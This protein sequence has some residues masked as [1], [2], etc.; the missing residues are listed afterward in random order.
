MSRWKKTRD[1]LLL[2]ASDANL[3]F[4]EVCSL[5]DRLGFQ[6][7]PGGGGHLIFHHPDLPEIINLQPRH[8]K[9]KPYQMK[10]VR[11]LILRYHLTA[12]DA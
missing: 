2:G 8:G 12:T 10:Q 3:D 11:E 1:K 6:R 7:R 5:L 9:G 4:D